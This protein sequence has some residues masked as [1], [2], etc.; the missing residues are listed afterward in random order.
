MYP[1]FCAYAKRLLCGEHPT[2]PAGVCPASV[3]VAD[4]GVFFLFYGRTSRR[5]GVFGRPA[6]AFDGEFPAPDFQS[7]P[8]TPANARTLQGYF[9]H[10]KPVSR[11][12]RRVSFGFG[13]RL[14]LAIP[15]F[16]E[17]CREKNVFPVIA[18]QSMRELTL[19]GR[20]YD[21]VLA[22]AVF[23]A[24]ETGYKDGFGTDGDHL[25]HLH[26]IEYALKCGYSMITL[27]CSDYMPQST[28]A[29]AAL[30]AAYLQY[31]AELRQRLEET[32]LNRTIALNGG[33]SLSFAKKDLMECTVLYYDCVSFVQTVYE[34][35]IRP[36]QGDLEVSID[37]SA[38]VTTL[39][40]HYFFANELRRHKVEF[41]SLAPRFCGEFQKGVDYRGDV[42]AF[43][44]E[45]AGHYAIAQTLGY[46]LSVHSGSDKF[47]I[48]PSVREL[49][50]AGYHLKVSG[51]NWLEAL[52]VVAQE[53][54]SLF[55]RIYACALD[56]LDSAKAFYHISADSR[57]APDISSVPD[58]RLAETVF[59]CDDG[60]QAVHITYGYIL[61]ARQGGVPV[62]R[63]ALFQTL[64]AG[65][66]TNRQ[67]ILQHL[68]RHF[69]ALG[70]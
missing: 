7:C 51:T 23:A 61:N 9:P 47:S 13:D 8:L 44:Q 56:C 2:P 35:L 25:K 55:R 22:D 12:G 66:E 21:M 50:G 65:R 67:N 49:S 41:G 11:K 40:N 26:E 33:Q 14:G 63:D 16:L 6:G 62:Y 15:A 60:R 34:T 4:G 19:T 27:D 28:P 38:A 1:A 68:G 42:A 43:R 31:P 29:G 30:E 32:Y 20:T 39:Q 10:L 70:I 5:L 46:K 36:Y 58:D 64:H 17:L 3:E 37:E 24:F 69:A 18:Q 52:K 53:N 57:S 45:Y 59:Q 54:P 48:F